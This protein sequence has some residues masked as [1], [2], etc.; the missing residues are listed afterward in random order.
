MAKSIFKL[1]IIKPDMEHKFHEFWIEKKQ[2][3]D[4]GTPLHAAMLADTD[5][6]EAKNLVE[7]KSLAAKKYPGRTVEVSRIG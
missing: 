2:V 6:F 5:M 4:D 7:A 3:S 1:N